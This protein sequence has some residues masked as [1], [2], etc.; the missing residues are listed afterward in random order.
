M[1][2]TPQRRQGR[3]SSVPENLLEVNG[4]SRKSKLRYVNFVLVSPDVSLHSVS[5]CLSHER[6]YCCAGVRYGDTERAFKVHTDC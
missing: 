5:A 3:E 6:E 2:T 1:Q 4:R